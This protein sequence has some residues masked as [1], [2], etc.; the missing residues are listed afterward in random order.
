MAFVIAA[1]ASSNGKT[2]LSILI[3]S[4]A[5]RNGEST[6]TFK[7]GPDYLDPQLL[8]AVTERPCRNLDTI[9][10][11]KNWV[12]NSFNLYGSAA[13]YAFIE[14]VMGLFDGIGSSDKGSTADI[15]R[16]LNLPLLLVVDARGQAGSIAALVKGFKDF[17][18]TLNIAG[19]VLNKVNSSRHKVLL[20]EALTKINVK[21]LG[22][23][24]KDDYLSIPSRSLGLQ[25]AHEI[26]NIEKLINTWASI[27]EKNLDFCSLRPLLKA[28][29]QS[30][31]LSNILFKN[32]LKNPRLKRTT[33][34]IAEDKAFHFRYP[35][36]K[37]CLEE[38]GINLIKWQITQDSPIPKQAKGL[39]IPGGFPEQFAEEISQCKRSL[40]SIKEFL[41]NYP[42]Y[43]ECGGMLILGKSL[44]DTNEKK[45][46]MAGILPFNA[47]EGKLKVGYR[48]LTAISNSLISNK[49][50]LINGH[51]FHRWKLDINGSNDLDITKKEPMIQS[52]M[53]L[54]SPWEIRGW[55]IDTRQ[56]GW[57]NKNFHAS[58]IHLHWAS[59]PSI[60]QNWSSIVHKHI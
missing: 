43:A 23:L 30:N 6:Q 12:V 46:P 44:S 9:L 32:N 50:D 24:P 34:A 48:K 5:R 16:L 28:P 21:V 38:L 59:S 27:A 29:S 18:H 14:G 41:N 17:D 31:S 35:E 1:P 11:G 45:F 55:G 8:S 37:E 53:N 42:I 60:L 49:G 54:Y 15:A 47:K 39:I 56:E 2:L 4:W 52:S 51:E 22:C 57:S 26:S 10:C 36:T 25:P 58:W 33:I 3:A 19:V 20:T 7:I 13:E 40:N